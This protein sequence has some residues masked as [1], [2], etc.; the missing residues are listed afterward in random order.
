MRRKFL[1]RN[2]GKSYFF[3]TSKD[4][5]SHIAS[6][7]NLEW[8]KIQRKFPFTVHWR[9]DEEAVF[10]SEHNWVASASGKTFEHKA[11]PFIM[12]KQNAAEIQ[13]DVKFFH[14]FLTSDWD[15]IDVWWIIFGC[16]RD[17]ATLR[18]QFWF[19]TQIVSNHSP[20]HD[21]VTLL[22]FY[23]YNTRRYPWLIFL[24]K[25]IFRF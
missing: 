4:F 24:S 9:C 3:R 22:K 20:A 2:R 13:L 15:K 18:L 8:L 6:Y 19:T 11:I 12:D 5:F 21:S 7:S 14:K 16:A 10:R 25:L 23:F 17:F 1:K